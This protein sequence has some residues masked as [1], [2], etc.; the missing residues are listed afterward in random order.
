[1]PEQIQKGWLHT[2]EGNKF[3]PTT[4]IENV[5]TRSGFP[6]D[7]QVRKYFT[8]LETQNTTQFT[9]IE[10]SLRV[11]S[12]HIS[13]LQNIVI[14][15]YNEI[16]DKLKNFQDADDGTFWITDKEG[17]VIAYINNEGLHVIDIK[18]K[19]GKTMSEIETDVKDLQTKNADKESRLKS[20]ENQI[21]A[22]GNI[23]Q[24]IGAVDTL[25]TNITDYQNGDVIVVTSTGKEYVLSEEQWV[26]LGD[27]SA[28]L[29]AIEHLYAIVG[30]PDTIESTHEERLD[31]L[32]TNLA[33][34]A[35]TRDEADKM[36]NQTLESLQDNVNWVDD[37]NKLFIIDQNNK[38]IAYFDE[39]GLTIYNIVIQSGQNKKDLQV[40]GIYFSDK[41]SVTINWIT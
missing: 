34:E 11:Q 13:N 23:M 30:N 14:N 39:C 5:Y 12:N 37:D 32:E 25:P 19:S 40:N 20:V 38:V 26:E 17:N 8:S 41:E 6:Y 10:D 36:I 22:L 18:I 29:D 2:R 7:D 16:L 27:T 31:L 4:L 9:D 33:E 24:F 35:N 28:E 3:A 15:N 1:M 21:H